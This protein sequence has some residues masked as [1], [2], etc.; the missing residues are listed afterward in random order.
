MRRAGARRS[1][2]RHPRWLRVIRP[3][4]SRS[5]CRSRPAA[6]PTSS[7]ASSPT[8]CSRRSASRSS[9]TTS[10]ADRRR[11]ARSRRKSPPDG[12]TLFVTT[13]TSHSA[14][15]YLF[16]KLTYDPVKDFTP[17]AQ[18][19]RIPVILVVDPKLPH[20]QPAGARR[21]REGQSRQ[22]VVR[23]RQQHRAGGGRERS[24]SRPAST[25]ITVP[26]KSTPQAMTDVMGGQF[27]YAVADM[28]SARRSSRPAR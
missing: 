25:V 17:M 26:Y 22:G 11:S 7:R 8:S 21:V 15:P 12:Y 10:R 14:N 27:T 13:N 20:Q 2:W 5:S 4:R 19:M 28:A 6:P 9:S 1:R 3:G 18:I 16:K 23:L 24:R